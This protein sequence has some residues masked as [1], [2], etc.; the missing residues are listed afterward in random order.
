[1]SLVLTLLVGA[2]GIYMVS[3]HYKTA[4][5][6]NFHLS[7]GG[8]VI[9]AAIIL[10]VVTVVAFLAANRVKSSQSSAQATTGFKESR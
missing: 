1:M 8:T 7:D 3:T 5:V 4:D 10:L 9:V 2:D 6:N